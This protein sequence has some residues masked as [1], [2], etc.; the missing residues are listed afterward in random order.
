[1]E[2]EK[3]NNEIKANEKTDNLSVE[4]F[5]VTDE[6][7]ENEFI[8]PEIAEATEVTPDEEVFAEPKKPKK[9]KQP[10]PE[11]T[12]NPAD[13]KH[14]IRM[15]VVLTVICAVIALLLS[16]VNDLTKDVIAENTIKA[17]NAA[18]LRVYPEGDLVEMYGG[19]GVVKADY[20]GEQISGKVYRI[21]KDGAFIG[22]CINVEPNGYENPINMMVGINTENTVVGLTIVEMK[23]TAGV[24][25]KTNSEGFLGQFLNKTGPFAVGESIDG[26]AGATI[27]SKAVTKGVNMA[28]VLADKLTNDPTHGTE[29]AETQPVETE[30][31]ETEP[32]ET[33]PPETEAEETAPVETE[34]EETEPAETNPPETQA[35]ETWPVETQPVVTWPVETQPVVTW[36]VETE[37]PETTPP[38]T[39]PA[40]IESEEE[41]FDFETE[42]GDE[43]ITEPDTTDEETSESDI[44][45]EEETFDFETEEGDEWITEPN[46]T[47]ENDE[48]E[49]TE[50]ESETERDAS[51]PHSI[52]R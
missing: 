39:E 42:E 17:R 46:E 26:I 3:L 28:K 43:W 23:E 15:V 18:I 12:E 13:I 47:V 38:E 49:T 11:K 44:E 14:S 19:D 9:E 24:G 33:D 6:Y 4:G 31:A 27:S 32:V 35:P 7:I 5:E 25:S 37:A 30:P 45:S 40:E 48:S 51:F 34:P 20:D 10:K 16:V 52:K 50:T 8:D 36:P 2:N 41:T 22:Y 1:M 29:P 21:Y